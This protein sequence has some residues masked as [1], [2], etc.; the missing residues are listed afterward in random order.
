MNKYVGE[1]EKAVR[2]VFD[3]AKQNAPAVIFFDEIDAIAGER[4][5]GGTDSEATERVVSQLLTELD[6]IE[7]LEDV[8]V[9]A[10]SNRPD[11]IDKAILRP[12]RLDRKVKVPVPDLEAREEIFRIHLEGT[13]LEDVDIEDLA[14]MTE[15]FTGSD[16]E[17]VTREASMLAMRDYMK[18]NDPE[19]L[20]KNMDALKLTQDYLRRAVEKVGPSLNEEDREKYNSMAEEVNSI[21]EA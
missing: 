7:E 4:D 2:E 16:I 18:G 3:K 15:G 6:G 21:V 13:P 17:S 12:G 19:N 10:A 11:M 8:V 1:S 5:G 20:E 14:E 9:I